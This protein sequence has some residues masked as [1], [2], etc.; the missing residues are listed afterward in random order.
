M[1]NMLIVFL[2]MSV[3]KEPP[4]F[5][6]VSRH[7]GNDV[8]HPRDVMTIMSEEFRLDMRLTHSE[9]PRIF[10]P[11]SEDASDVRGAR[12]CQKI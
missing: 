3:A 11:T 7:F 2:I 4:F 6:S 8:V 12:I 5:I 9:Q 10:S 1:T